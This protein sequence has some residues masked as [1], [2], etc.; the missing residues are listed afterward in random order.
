MN[1][2]QSAWRNFLEQGMLAKLVIVNFAVFLTVNVVSQF[3]HT[4]VLEYIAMPMELETFLYRFWTFF[5][6]MFVHQNFWHFFWNM[7]TLY[8]F[9]QVMH[10]LLG[11]QKLLYVYTMSGMAGATLMLLITLFVPSAFSNAILL[12]ASASVLGVGALMA[13]LAPG[14]R[15]LLWGIVDLPFGAFFFV[16]FCLTTVLD[17][18][19]NTG[20]KIAHVGG[21]LFGLT[22]G[23]LLKRG[24]R[25]ETPTFSRRK[26]KVVHRQNNA[27][28]NNNYNEETRMNMLL[29]KISKSG[30]DSLS[31]IEKDELFKLSKRR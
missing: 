10:N 1:P 26:L 21:T 31:Q 6:Y 20:G 11:D 18:T 16:V 12:G 25:F 15:V 24:I 5:T 7:L 23:Y 17:L 30:Y 29:D 4:R 14:Y 8:F 9:A 22:Y 3:A 13:M 28:V 27:T 2:L 19:V